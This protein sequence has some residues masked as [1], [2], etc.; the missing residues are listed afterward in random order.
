MVD[1]DAA[2]NPPSIGPENP[3]RRRWALALFVGLL[4]GAA[5][6]A[7]VW[8]G[9]P[10][11]FIAETLLHVSPDEPRV[12][13][14]KE[15]AGT[16]DFERWKKTQRQLV[17]SPA[18]LNSALQKKEVSALPLVTQQVDQLAW[19]QEGR[20]SHLPGRFRNYERQ[21]PLRGSANGGNPR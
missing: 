8:L 15:D 12:L 9:V 2:Q 20:H 14:S 11:Q 10:H 19:L 4:L 6:S 13:R 21:R 16:V 5:T 1:S 17:C 7:V 18:V 3:P